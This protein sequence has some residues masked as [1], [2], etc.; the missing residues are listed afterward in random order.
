MIPIVLDGLHHTVTY[1]GAQGTLGADSGLKSIAQLSARMSY[2]FMCLT[3]SWGVLTA[4]GWVRRL[5]GRKTL[6]AGHL[7]LAIL[8]L[9][10]GVIH[11]MAFLFLTTGAWSLPRLLIPLL[12]GTLLRHTLGIVGLE[13][14]LAIGITAGVYRWISY[15]RYLWLHRLAYPAVGITAVH[16]VF[17]A[18]ANGHLAVLWLAGITLLVPAILLTVLRFLPHHTLERI[19]LVEEQVW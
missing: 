14:M 5:T 6:R 10:F 17:G 11:A 8:T 7:A 4:T 19:G 3:L 15:R 16:S 9:C 13:L 1:V 18:W 12:P 2:A